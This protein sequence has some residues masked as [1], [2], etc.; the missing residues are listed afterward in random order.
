MAKSMNELKKEIE[1]QGFKWKDALEILKAHTDGKSVREAM[2][3]GWTVKEIETVLVNEFNKPESEEVEGKEQASEK[4]PHSSVAAHAEA[5]ASL[6][7][8]YI[9]PGGF[10]WQFTI[11]SGLD[12]EEMVALLERAKAA[13]AWLLKKK[14]AP[15]VPYQNNRANASDQ[16]T[17]GNGEEAPLCPTHNKPMKPSKHGK[18]FY[19]PV[20]IADDDGTG[21][22]VYCKQQVK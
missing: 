1:G 5:P 11:R 12:A 8:Y 21:R 22:P 16:Q 4:K 10:R 20:K 2:A 19:C 17:G 9:S 14:Y 15:Y 18:G 6:N 13:E 3:E 7:T